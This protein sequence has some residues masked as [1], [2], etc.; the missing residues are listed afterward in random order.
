MNVVFIYADKASV[1]HGISAADKSFSR[2]TFRKLQLKQ[3]TELNT[4]EFHQIH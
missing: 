1:A 4:Q 3:E 2:E